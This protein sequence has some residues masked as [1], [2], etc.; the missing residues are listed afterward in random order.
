M[1][2]C[3][4]I[5]VSVDFTKTSRHSFK[6]ALFL[7]QRTGFEVVLVHI[8]SDRNKTEADFEEL[9]EEMVVEAGDRARNV[10]V[11]HRIIPGNKGDVVER[12]SQTFDQLNPVYLVIGYEIKTGFGKLLGPNIQKIIYETKYPVIA[13]KNEERID[14]LKTLY[15][16]LTLSNY[17]RQKTNISIKLVQDMDLELVLLPLKIN[18]TKKDDVHMDIMVKNMVEKFISSE[19]RYRIQY[20]EGKDELD[21]VLGVT[22]DDNYSLTSVVFESSPDFFDRFMKSREEKLL[23][24]TKDPLLIVKS[25]HSPYLY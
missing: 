9:I 4:R 17:S 6:E 10:E 14:Q 16:P 1:E 11:N 22:H 20:L 2:N 12:L 18:H 7:G 13:L 23:E 21:L 8:N 15:F 24:R 5:A 25:H 3:K 19:I